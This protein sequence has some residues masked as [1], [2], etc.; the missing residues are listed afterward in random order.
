MIGTNDAPES[1]HVVPSLTT[2]RV[3][4]AELAAAAAE[5]LIDVITH[6]ERPSVQKYL[7]C[8]LLIRDSTGPCRSIAYGV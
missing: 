8:E 5:I 2:L 7:D 4:Y 6:G 3:P 1:L